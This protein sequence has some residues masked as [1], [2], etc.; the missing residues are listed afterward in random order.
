M[1]WL[2]L[3][4]ILGTIAVMLIVLMIANILNLLSIAVIWFVAAAG[5]VEGQRTV[6]LPCSPSICND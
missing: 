5:F 1:P 2:A 6:M 4:G 3:I